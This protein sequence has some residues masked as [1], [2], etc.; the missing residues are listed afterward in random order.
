METTVTTHVELTQEDMETVIAEKFN[1]KD[2]KNATI[3]IG[4]TVGADPLDIRYYATVD[5]E[6]TYQEEA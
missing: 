5:Y 1:F 2:N 4:H 3:T 6:A